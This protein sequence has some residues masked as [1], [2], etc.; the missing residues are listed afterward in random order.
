MEGVA[1]E[2]VTKQIDAAR[3][4]AKGRI[5]HDMK[6][7]FL[8]DRIAEAEAIE[9]T[10]EEMA[11]AIEEIATVYG[12]PVEAVMAQFRDQGRLAELSSQIRHRKVKE[13]VRQ[14][15]TLVE[16]APAQP[17]SPP[18]AETVPEAPRARGKKDKR[19]E[20]H[21]GAAKE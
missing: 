15:A 7:F 20:G 19:Q 3:A 6:R 11:A 4:D 8:L 10:K 2:E 17:A 14:L 9:V 12:H 21:E 18:P 5:E 13:R 16:E 1:E